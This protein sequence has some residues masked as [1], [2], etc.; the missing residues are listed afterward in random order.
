MFL[1]RKALLSQG[2]F[3]AAVHQL[4]LSLGA[5]RLSFADCQF[6]H[7]VGNLLTSRSSVGKWHARW[8]LICKC[9][10]DRILCEGSNTVDTAPRC[11]GFD[12]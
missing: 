11:M 1:P 7:C 12:T 6:S 4:P 2:G 10:E 9:S 5:R 8:W 3:H